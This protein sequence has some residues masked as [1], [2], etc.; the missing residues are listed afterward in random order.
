MVLIDRTLDLAAPASHGGSLLQ[1]VRYHDI[2]GVCFVQRYCCRGRHG[3]GTFVRFV[4]VNG[5]LV[6][7]VHGVQCL[8]FSAGR[9]GFVGLA[10]RWLSVRGLCAFGALPQRFLLNGS[11]ALPD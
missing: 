4:S 10:A 1:R 8:D 7:F 3:E 9:P 2:G 11:A 5:S 6:G